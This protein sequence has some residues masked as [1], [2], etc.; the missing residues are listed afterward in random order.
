MKKYF[1]IFFTLLCFWQILLLQ[2]CDEFLSAKPDKALATI[3]SVKDLRAILDNESM[4]NENYPAGGDIASDYYYLKEV[5]WAGRADFDRETYVWKPDV[6]LF[7]DW[8][9]SYESIFHTNV[10]LEHVDNVS[11]GKLTERDRNE[12]KGAAYF[13]RGFRLFLLSQIFAPPYS[14][15]ASDELLGIPVRLSADINERSVR[16]TQRQ[17][18]NQILTDLRAAA[19]FLPASSTAP[20]R[21]TKPAAFAALARVTLAMGDW[22]M[23]HTYADS[24]LQLNGVLLDYNTI[25]KS[26]ST[27]FQLFNDEVLLHARLLSSSGVFMPMYARVDSN[28]YNRYEDADLRKQLF[29]MPNSDGSFSFKGSYTGD[30]DCLWCATL[31]SGLATDE[32]YLIKAEAAARLNL[33]EE[34]LELLNFFLARRYDSLRWNLLDV[35]DHEELLQLILDH[36]EKSLAFRGNIRWSD[37]RRLNSEDQFKKTLSRRFG[38]TE[39]ELPPEDNRFTFLIPEEIIKTTGMPQNKR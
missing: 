29:F 21:P 31:F 25:D 9:M 30:G 27:P 10:V 14:E 6:D 7:S 20:T 13:Y 3:R 4:F 5:D 17:T 15:G 23:A 38:D 16:A 12:V 37:L 34:A 33:G 2:S 36:R 39:Y 19:F 8:F 26:S 28:L 22:K 18:Y 11:L 32:V 1:S 24:C 35:R